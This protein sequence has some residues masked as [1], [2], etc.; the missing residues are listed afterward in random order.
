MVVGTSVQRVDGVAKVTGKAR[1]TDDFTMPG[2]R[3]AKYLRSTIAHGRVSSIDTSQAKALPGVDG[4]FTFEDVPKRI[5]AT[6]GHPYSLDPH[7]MD[8]TD[9]Y[10]LTDHVRYMGDEIAIVV[11]VSDL[12]ATKALSLIDV[13]YE[14]YQPLVEAKDALAKDAVEIHKGTGNVVK[15]H[16]FVAGGDLD[17]VRKEC[18]QLLEGQYKTQIV[19]HCH[20]ENHTAYAYMDDL[21][22]IVIVS[23]TQIPHIARRI[24]AE[25]LEIDTGLIRVIKPTIGGG[26]GN[27]QDVILE[28]MVAFLTKKLDGIPVRLKL[29]REEGM[30]GTRVRHPFDVKVQIGLDQEGTVKLIHFDALSNTG[31]YASHGHSIVSAGAAKTHY[32]YP[33]AVYSC[34]AKTIYS[35][36]PAAGA[37]RAYGSPQMTFAIECAMEEAARTLGMD[38]AEFRLRNGARAGDKSQITKKP[39][40]TCGLLDSIKKGKDL[41]GWDKKRALWPKEQTGEVRNGLGVAIFSYGSGT[42]P[43]CV[44]PASARLILN[45]DG[46]AHLQVGATEIGQGSD[47]AFAQMA[48]ESLG[49]SFSKIHVVSCQ[50]TDVTPFDTGSYASRQTYVTGQAVMRTAEQL[51]AKILH[52]ASIISGLEATLITISGDNIVISESPEIV[53]MSVQDV[54]IDAYYNKERGG[55]ITAEATYKARNNPHVFGCTFVDLSVDIPLCRVKI[56]EIYN[57]HDSGIII[58]PLMA[59]G[60]VHGGMAMGIGAA[61]FEELMVDPDSGKIYNNNLLDYKVPTIMDIPDLG[62]AF[63]EPNEPTHPYGSKSLGEPPIISPAPAIRNAILDA[64]GVAIN[65]LPMSP[66]TIFKY[67]KNAGLI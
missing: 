4:V 9:R 59:E 22:R 53:V 8:I 46:S 38:S 37:M 21:E 67:F 35:N 60:Q 54:A 20:L 34:T 47:T 12:I 26:F 50:D 7:H 29:D 5:Y 63:V 55:Q 51:K 48:A 58:N 56:N 42:Y 43:V 65:E 25:A 39:I 41:I 19:Q 66:K 24:V 27:K 23:S 15:A 3:V 1:Y 62:A 17:A 45:Q 44:E 36:I 2:M 64:T 14:P 52:H 49:F 10:L 33:R 13:E 61:L 28:P 6:A 16:S 18:D 30:V 31:A 11:A 40:M 32:M 57:I